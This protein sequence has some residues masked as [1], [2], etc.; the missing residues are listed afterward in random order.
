MVH[1]TAVHD[2]SAV[3]I[4]A[5]LDGPRKVRVSLEIAELLQGVEVVVDSRRGGESYGV[6]NFSNRRWK[7]PFGHARLDA[8]ENAALTFG[9][10]GIGHGWIVR[11]FAPDVK[12]V[13]GRRI[14][15]TAGPSSQFPRD[16]AIRFPPGEFFSGNLDTEHPFPYSDRDRTHVLTY[17]CSEIPRSDVQLGPTFIVDQL[18]QTP[19]AGWR[20]PDQPENTPVRTNWFPTRK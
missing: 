20:S 19:W 7:A 6:A 18:C 1:P 2:G 11:M 4:P 16:I 5:H 17:T 15:R 10:G 14:N 9:E 13:F 8:L 12:H 3:A